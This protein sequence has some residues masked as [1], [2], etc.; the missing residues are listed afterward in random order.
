MSLSISDTNDLD[1]SGTDA[2]SNLDLDLNDNNNNNT[3]KNLIID[4]LR[5]ELNKLKQQLDEE[6]S[7]SKQAAE[8]G[9]S[10]LED[11][12]KL[13]TRNYELE[14]EIETIKTELESTNLVNFLPNFKTF[15]KH[16][17]FILYTK[18]KLIL[19]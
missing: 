12:K 10:L 15:I 9:L 4:R 19:I 17:S 14:G 5:L 13:Q 8:Y 3:N 6:K 2:N 18:I 7:N 1:L 11:Y 16:I